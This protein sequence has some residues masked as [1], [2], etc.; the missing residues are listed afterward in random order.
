MGQGTGPPPIPFEGWF[1]TN[2][3]SGP[4]VGLAPVPKA[5]MAKAAEYVAAERDGSIYSGTSPKS[6]QRM[7]SAAAGYFDRALKD[8]KTNQDKSVQKVRAFGMYFL[9]VL[10]PIPLA[11][12]SRRSSW[13]GG[14]V[15][16]L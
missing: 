12:S 6:P 4:P 9:L 1:P 8:S 13:A 2:Y 5:V 10:G 15:L 11:C 16:G 7:L 3:N 14:V